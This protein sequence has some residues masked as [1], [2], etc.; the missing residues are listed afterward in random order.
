MVR[1][2]ALSLA[3]AA[4]LL[5]GVTTATSAAADYVPGEVVVGYSAVPSTAVTA[6]VQ[7]RM[8]A[9]ALS[10]EAPEPAVQVLR[11]PR[12][13]TVP[14]AL[15]KLHGQRGVAYAVPNYIAHA[16]SAPGPWIPHDQGKT[17]SA[18]GWE[19]LQWNF[20]PASGVDAPTAWAHLRA[21]GRP[22]GKGVTVAVLDTGVAYRNWHQ[23]RRSPDFGRTHFVSPYDFV[24]DDRFPLDREGH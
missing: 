24:A 6:D 22:G 21:A 16:D 3:S 2:L 20:L 17:H 8:G 7:H 18:G 14:Q 23:F 19:R 15:R 4:A 1:A 11:L 5:L 13:E 12:G 9:R 10:T